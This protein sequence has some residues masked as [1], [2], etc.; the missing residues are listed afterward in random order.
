MRISLEIGYSHRLN[1]N[2][3]TRLNCSEF[4]RDLDSSSEILESATCRAI[5]QGLDGHVSR[6]RGGQKLTYYTYKG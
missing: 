6:S 3:S 4:E 1:L 5:L 2:S